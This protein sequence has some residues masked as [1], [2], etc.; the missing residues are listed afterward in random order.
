MLLHQEEQLQFSKYQELFSILIEPN[1]FWRRLNEM[2]NFSF[3]HDELKDKYSDKMGR[4]AENPIIMM[5]YILLKM[6]FKLSDRDLIKRTKTDMLF[7]YFLGYEPEETSFIDP[8]LLSKFRRTRLEDINLL[9]LLINKTVEKAL[10]AGVMETKVKII[11]DSTHTNAIYQ[12]ISPREE[13]IKRSKEVRK[14]VYEIDATKKATMPKKREATGLLEDE[15]EY[16]NELIELIDADD[17]LRNVTHIQEKVDYLKECIEDTETEIEYAKKQD[18]RIGHKTADTSFF[19]FKTHIAMTP[20]RIITAA[21][22]TSGEKHDGKELVDLIEK[23]E[24]AGLK[25][26]AVI[27]DGAYSEHAN[28]EY[29]NENEI[30]LASK[31]SKNITHGNKKDDKFEYNKDAG[32]YVCEAG[33]MAIKKIKSGSKKDKTGKN[34]EVELYFF[35][36]EKCKRCPKREGCYKEGSKSK[37]YSVKIKTQEQIK[38]MEYMDSEEFSTLYKERY[39]IEAKNGELKQQY[40]YGDATGC[41]I[42]SMNIQGASTIFLANMKRII[43]LIDQK[44]QKDEAVNP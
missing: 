38:H 6:H 16:C 13:L 37:T 24:E 23:S 27:G 9:D 20:D 12:H 33:H 1:N 40:G 2:V 28:I 31:F 44:K 15:I 17:I 5:K 7:K 41:G 36:I 19:G 18:A 32:M 26:E 29:T 30:K 35:D 22:I 4:P 10:E 43:K 39:K 14:A 34:T 3:V 21:T 8:S 25:V 42:L 11:V